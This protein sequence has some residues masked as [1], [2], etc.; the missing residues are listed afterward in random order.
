MDKE[1]RRCACGREFSKNYIAR[2][3][4]K[5]VAAIRSAEEQRRG[6]RKYKGKRKMCECGKEMAATN[7]SRHKREECPNR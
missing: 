6:P 4:K 7:Y 1:R 2:Q 3:R 5:C